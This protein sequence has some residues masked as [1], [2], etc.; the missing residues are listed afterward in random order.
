MRTRNARGRFAF[1]VC[2][3]IADKN[4]RRRAREKL[5]N[6]KKKKKTAGKYTHRAHSERP[7]CTPQSR[8]RISSFF[9]PNNWSTDEFRAGRTNQTKILKTYFVGSVS[10]FVIQFKFPIIKVPYSPLMVCYGVSN[11]LVRPQPFR[12]SPRAERR[13]RIVRLHRKINHNRIRLF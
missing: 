11:R 13:L 7:F 10:G 4:V 6:Y 5:I 2:G 12:K 8:P 3:L 1:G 9:W